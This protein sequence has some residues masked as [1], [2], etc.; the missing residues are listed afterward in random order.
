MQ[1][2]KAVEGNPPKKRRLSLLPHNYKRIKAK[3]NVEGKDLYLIRAPAEFDMGQLDGTKLTLD[4][5]THH[6][7]PK[8][9]VGGQYVAD[10]TIDN[11]KNNPLIAVQST[12]EGSVVKGTICIRHS[13]TVPDPVIPPQACPATH[14]RFAA[15]LTEHLKQRYVPFGLDIKSE[16]TATTPKK[17]KVH[18]KHRRT[19][20]DQSIV[21]NEV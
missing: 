10:V 1:A 17:S 6:I 15:D 9:G 18:R 16:F 4:A 21:T 13:V 20:M 19:I 5:G 12:D 11:V 2:N 14:K 7:T 8:E 3:L